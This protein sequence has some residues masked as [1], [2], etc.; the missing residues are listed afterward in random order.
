MSSQATQLLTLAR[1]G[2]AAA[3][4]LL[5]ELYRTRLKQLVRIRM[6][7][8]LLARFDI[9]DVV[10]ETLA[11]A[12][13]HWN[14]FTASAERPFYA[15]LREIACHR[16]IDLHRRHVRAQRRSVTRE[17]SL[18]APPISAAARRDLA[19][20]L[21]DS[22]LSPSRRVERRERDARVHAALRQLSAMDR[23]VLEMRFLEELSVE[24]IAEVLGVSYSVVTSRQLRA[25]QRLG[26]LMRGPGD[27]S[28]T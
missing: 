22:S 14:D 13:V 19:R 6:D 11:L 10:Q 21:A 5:L 2:D 3:L 12:Y 27:S 20:R 18:S 1:Q 16:L 15:W 4:H 25:L 9:S 28:G 24:E 7:R 23:E 8:R 17:E 26:A